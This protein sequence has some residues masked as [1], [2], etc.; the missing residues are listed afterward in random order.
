MFFIALRLE[1]LRTLSHALDRLPAAVLDTVRCN[2]GILCG[3]RLKAVK[4]LLESHHIAIRFDRKALC[5]PVRLPDTNDHLFL[6]SIEKG[7][8]SRSPFDLLL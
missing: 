5:F 6:Q 2:A 4:V 1:Q 8:V 3:I 7:P